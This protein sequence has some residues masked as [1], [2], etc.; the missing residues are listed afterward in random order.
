MSLGKRKQSEAS[1]TLCN[2]R[3]SVEIY[4]PDEILLKIFQY[5]YHLDLCAAGCVNRQWYRVASDASLWNVVRL[6]NETV[7]EGALEK[8]CVRRTSALHLGQAT[9]RSPLVFY[10]RLCYLRKLDAS[11]LQS[12]EILPELFS[13]CPH[14]THLNLRGQNL[15]AHQIF[16]TMR[17][18]RCLLEYLDVS[19]AW[20]S[21]EN[22]LYLCSFLASAKYLRYLRVSWMLGEPCLA[23]LVGSLQSSLELLDISGYRE[24]LS[25]DLVLCLARRCPKLTHLDISDSHAVSEAVIDT[26]NDVLISLTHLRLSRCYYVHPF[27]LLSLADHPSLLHLT[28]LPEVGWSAVAIE[29]LRAAGLTVNEPSQHIWKSDIFEEFFQER[30]WI[31]FPSPQQRGKQPKRN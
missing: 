21:E 29:D 25:N 18:K 12:S 23:Q 26:L 11:G 9:L 30:G 7:P 2:K 20:I 16:K 10:L 22:S 15:A 3:R 27:S 8:L 28:V 4:L 24:T 14:L 17:T 19:M 13:L 31:T 6:Q 1:P 5:L